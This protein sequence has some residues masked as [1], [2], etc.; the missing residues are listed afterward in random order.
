MFDFIDPKREGRGGVAETVIGLVLA[1]AFVSM[2][3]AAKAATSVPGGRIL[4]PVLGIAAFGA[5]CAWLGARF[6]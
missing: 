2:L 4:A 1:M 5:A 3:V 6:L